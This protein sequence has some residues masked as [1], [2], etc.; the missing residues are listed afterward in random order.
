MRNNTLLETVVVG[1]I[2]HCN[3]LSIY[4]LIRAGLVLMNALKH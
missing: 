3:N 2:H 4:V 1:G